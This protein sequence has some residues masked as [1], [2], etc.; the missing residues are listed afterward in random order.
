ML[1]LMC[2]DGSFAL[3]NATCYTKVNMDVG[4]TFLFCLQRNISDKMPALIY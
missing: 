4:Y 3:R 2:S 1:P